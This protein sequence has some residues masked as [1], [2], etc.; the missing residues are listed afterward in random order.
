MNEEIKKKFVKFSLIGIVAIV[1]GIFIHLVSGL[2]FPWIDDPVYSLIV[3]STLVGLSV[4]IF[5][6]MA[7]TKKK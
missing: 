3:K 6:S 4:G 5:V 7:A 1:I 2:L